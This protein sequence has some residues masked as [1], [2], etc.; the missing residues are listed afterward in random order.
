MI[1][2]TTTST[3][4]AALRPQGG[5]AEERTMIEIMRAT[6]HQATRAVVEVSEE[7]DHPTMAVHPAEK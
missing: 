3:E 5:R 1:M 4:G 6:D 7:I 2:D